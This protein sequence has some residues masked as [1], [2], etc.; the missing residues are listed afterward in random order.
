VSL[1]DTGADS[2]TER[3]AAEAGSEGDAGGD[4]VERHWHLAECCYYAETDASFRVKFKFVP[5]CQ[6]V[7]P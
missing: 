5:A 1:D 6:W 4:H 3:A 7:A 2:D